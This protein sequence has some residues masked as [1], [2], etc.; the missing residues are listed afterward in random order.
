[1]KNKKPLTYNLKTALEELEPN[2]MKDDERVLELKERV[3]KLSEMDQK[4]LLLYLELGSMSRVGKVLKV[5]PSTV[6][7]YISRIREKLTVRN[8]WGR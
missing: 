2:I 8:S 1:M 4:I 6:Y 3:L 7:I 5:S